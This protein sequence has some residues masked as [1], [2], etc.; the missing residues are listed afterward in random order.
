MK[1]CVIIPFYNRS[2]S[3][4]RAILSVI[5]QDIYHFRDDVNIEILIVDDGSKTSEKLILNNICK[6]FKTV[7]MLSYESNE[8]A[9]YARNFGLLNAGDSDFIVFLDSDECFKINFF[10]S[11]HLHLERKLDWICTGFEVVSQFRRR[12]I[13]VKDF[14]RTDIPT[15]ILKDGGHLKTSCMVFS[16]ECLSSV[17]WDEELSRFQDIDF[18]LQLYLAGYNVNYIPKSLVDCYKDQPNRISS[19]G[20][21]M[22]FHLFI[23][24]FE[25]TIDSNLLCIYRLRRLPYLLMQEGEYWQCVIEI[26]LVKNSGCRISWTERFRALLILLVN[27]VVSFLKSLFLRTKLVLS[28]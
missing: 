23:K 18:V 7:R 6:E 10:S 16:K 26:I 19:N 2:M 21:S 5:N 8:G 15:F 27:F 24:K 4:E 1:I 17:R 25:G 22:A 20:G 28:R 11:I 13:Y 3:I 12:D 14:V 9:N